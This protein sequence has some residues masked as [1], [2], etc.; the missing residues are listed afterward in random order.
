[1]GFLGSGTERDAEVS[2]KG[3][4]T[5]VIRRHGSI[6]SLTAAPGAQTVRHSLTKPTY[7]LLDSVAIGKTKKPPCGGG[8]SFQICPALTRPSCGRRI[9]LPAAAAGAKK[10]RAARF[11][12]YPSGR[13]FASTSQRQNVPNGVGIYNMRP[14][15]PVNTLCEAFPL[16]SHSRVQDPPRMELP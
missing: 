5:R 11:G 7:R 14:K 8:F 12:N 2:N 3:H 15:V 4:R 13:D 9:A 10:K 1:M 6:G 16:M